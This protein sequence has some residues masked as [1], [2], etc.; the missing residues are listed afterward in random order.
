MQ[1]YILISFTFAIL[2]IGIFFFT[3]EKKRPQPRDIMPIVIMCVVSALGRIVF[4][5][6]PQVQPSTAIIIIMGICYGRQA[7]FIT[8]AMT[9]LVSN[10]ILGQGPWTIWQMTAWGIIGFLAG[11]IRCYPFGQT[12]ES[13]FKKTTHILLVAVFGFFSAFLFSMI[14]DIWTIASIG[15]ALTPSLAISIFTT[16]M[17]FNISH[18]IGNVIFIFLLYPAFAKKLLR[19]KHKY[20]ILKG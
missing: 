19:L 13:N 7:G 20:G 12:T 6:I 15:S 16:G 18:A 8:G 14:T 3:Y 1:N 10:M 2:L 11:F 17:I 9:A 5:F 4:N